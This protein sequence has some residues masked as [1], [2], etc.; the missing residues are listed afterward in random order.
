MGWI[1]RDENVFDKS[2]NVQEKSH[3]ITHGQSYAQGNQKTNNLQKSQTKT[4]KPLRKRQA[5]RLKHRGNTE[6]NED[7]CHGPVT[8]VTPRVQQSPG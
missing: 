1:V 6:R 4:V 7:K 2:Q 8:V 5:E 3:N